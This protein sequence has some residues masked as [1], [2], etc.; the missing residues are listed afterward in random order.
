MRTAVGIAALAVTALLP[1]APAA[2]SEPW[3][4]HCGF[5]AVTDHTRDDGTLIVEID[6][7][8]VFFG[9]DAAGLARSGTLTCTLVEGLNH[10]SPVLHT[11]RSALTPGAAAIAP[12]VVSV[13]PSDPVGWVYV[14][15]SVDV[16]GEPTRY[17]D[18]EGGGLGNGR[19]TTDPGA[20]CG[21]I[22]G[23]PSTDLPGDEPDPESLLDG[24]VCP[25]LALLFPPE[26]DVTG[27]WD[28][29]PYGA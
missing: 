29:P 24:L 26:G 2:A 28:C 6:G 15:T 18:P 9:S 4:E 22:F 3:G 10:D 13:R 1:A 25:A 5:S 21:P 27:I 11:E 20:S 23:W 12:T 14:C 17:W 16:V 7:G 19:W 8:P